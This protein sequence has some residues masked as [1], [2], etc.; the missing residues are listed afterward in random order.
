MAMRVYPYLHRKYIYISSA[1]RRPTRDTSPAPQVYLYH[2][3]TRRRPT[4]AFIASTYVLTTHYIAREG[5][6]SR[7]R[8]MNEISSRATRYYVSCDV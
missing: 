5:Q 4:C 7:A 8:F 1:P 2:Y 3:G 6:I